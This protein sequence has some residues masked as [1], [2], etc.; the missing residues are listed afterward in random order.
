[1]R[2]VPGY[3]LLRRVIPAY[4]PGFPRL[5]REASAEGYAEASRAGRRRSPPSLSRASEDPPK[6]LKRRRWTMFIAFLPA[7][8]EAFG[9]QARA[10]S[11]RFDCGEAGPGHRAKTGDLGTLE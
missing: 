9:G 7:C 4:R 11:P 10:C 2:V 5:R 6:P 3:T 1:M 8:A